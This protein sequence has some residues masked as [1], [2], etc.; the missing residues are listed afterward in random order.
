MLPGGN[1]RT[2]V[3]VPPFPP[4]AARGR[5][6]IVV[7]T[8]GRELRDFLGNYT[9]LVHGY[10]CPEVE[11]QIVHQLRRGSSFG[12]PTEAEVEMGELLVE[13]F[14]TIERVRFTNSGTEAVMMAIRAAR[15]VTGHRTVLRFAG[16]YHGSYDDV[17]PA[18]AAG[19]ASAAGS[20]SIEVPYGDARAVARALAGRGADVACV[21]LDLMPNRAGLVPA[22]PAFVA[23][24]AEA[25]RGSG[26][27]LV[28]DEV[29]T[30]RLRVEGLHAEYGI[31]PDLVVLG[32]WIGGGLP[33]GA[34]GGRSDVMERFDPARGDRLE[35]G[36]T[37]AANPLSLAAGAAA[38]RLLDADA[39]RSINALGDRLRAAL[40]DRGYRVA[41]SGSLLRISRPGISI[42]D[43]WWRL[44][45][46]GILIAASGLMCTSTAMDDA[47][48]DDTIRIL[49]GI[50]V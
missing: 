36:G 9:A 40:R 48:L 14:P 16:C 35:H 3:F 29:I 5:G 47:F 11:A 7:D 25:C 2:T 17:L 27:L 33:I 39:V 18:S 32:K 34:F 43:L 4:Y 8:R 22:D 49:D 1:T 30:S 24:V 37:F 45:D 31:K 13:R 41:G 23:A 12:L 15:A 10:G 21:L 19:V 42:T 28:V 38:V 50:T 20:D 46:A 6:P 26:A 44:Y